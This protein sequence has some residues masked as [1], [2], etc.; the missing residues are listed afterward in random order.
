MNA[1]IFSSRR[2]IVLISFSILS[3]PNY[4]KSTK[5]TWHLIF[6]LVLGQHFLELLTGS[7]LVKDMMKTLAKDMDHHP[8][9]E[10][11]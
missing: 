9:N 7:S 4:N 2:K 8:K 1:Y 10:D 11:R 6:Y 5:I 3:F